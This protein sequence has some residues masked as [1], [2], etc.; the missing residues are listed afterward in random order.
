MTILEDVVSQEAQYDEYV[1][2][3]LSDRYVLAWIL[4]YTTKEFAEMSVSTI[5]TQCIADDVRI[6]KRKLLPER[7]KGQN[8]EDV[9]PREGTIF[10]DVRFSAYIQKGKEPIKILLNVEA[11][12][13]FHLKY[14]IITRGIFYGAR[15]ISSQMHTEFTPEDYSD[16]KK[17]YSIWICM[18]T[19]DYIGN[20]ISE[21]HIQKTD[22]L[23]GI[24]DEKDAYDKLSVVLICLNG[25]KKDRKKGEG[26]VGLLNTLLAPD[27]DAD[28]KI[29][30]LKEQYEIPIREQ[31][32]RELGHMCNLGEG[33]RED[34]LE[35]GLE[36]GMQKGKAEGKEEGLQAL[37]NT[38]KPMLL[39]AE[40]IIAAIRKNDIY[41]DV[42]EEQIRKYF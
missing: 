1:K 6:S 35:E 18:N 28:N 17:V 12:K 8:T 33:I 26:V 24:P 2:Q 21:Y 34:A 10:Y 20:A 11:Q 27:I 41:K 39:T 30:I 23:P 29:K 36:L 13:K 32:G 7:I 38:L 31:M 9:V 16:L 3:I 25:T 15:M 14:P 40:D 37:V 5:A 19:P 4:K 22:I 42:A